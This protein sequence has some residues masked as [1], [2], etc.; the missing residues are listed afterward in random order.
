M[1]PHTRSRHM[2]LLAGF[3]MA[4][5]VYIFF[6]E[7]W[8]HDTWFHLQRLQDIEMQFGDGRFFTYFAENAAQGKGLPVWVYY[9]QWIYWPAMF[10]RSVGASPLVALKLVYCIFLVVCCVGVYRLFRLG[11]DEP[12]AALGTLL[13]ITSNYVIGE[14]FQRAAYAEFM[15]VALLP[16]LLVA[17]HHSVLSGDRAPRVT[18]VLLA[19]LMILFHPLSFMNAGYAVAAYAVYTAIRWRQP[20]RQLLQLVPLFG[21]A[22]GLTAFYW[23]PAVIETRYVLGAEGVPTPLRETFLTIP[24]YFN[25]ASILSLGFVLTLSSLAVAGCLLLVSNKAESRMQ[26][27]S[28]PLVA[29]IVACIFLTLRVSEPLY[30]NISLLASNLWVWRVLYPLTLLVA[31]FTM[32]NCR[33]LPSRWRSPMALNAL[34]WLAVVQAVVFVLWHTASEL[35][36][37]PFEID[38]I[39]RSLV[40][41]SQ[42]LE[43]FGVDEY[44]P[45]LRVI[46]RLG[47]E[48]REIR[49]ILPAGRYEMSFDI[50]DGDAA[51][52]IHVPR[53][54]NTRYK[55]WI[56]GVPTPVYADQAGEMVIAPGGRTGTVALRFTRPPYVTWSTYLSGAS[57]V[58]LLAGI[59]RGRRTR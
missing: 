43:G 10:L 2:V 22:L 27:S 23:L 26:R 12:A 19:G 50:N 56:D 8:G 6:L 4:A 42:R 9:S 29:G 14:I 44:L 57:V 53:Y 58:L 46:P 59:A 20:Y 34:A 36:V 38:E 7:P 33:A 25:F 48:C 30:I 49:S 45:Q 11:T 47:T 32:D 18:L 21:L 40:V 16:A 39:E 1:L 15:S 13:F 52:C 3:I 17:L 35:S 37:R 55:A 51:T 41:E 5:C 54:W 31:I 28:W 24:R